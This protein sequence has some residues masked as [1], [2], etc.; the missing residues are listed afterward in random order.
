MQTIVVL[1]FHF[2]IYL[3]THS[4]AQCMCDFSLLACM[5]AI[6]TNIINRVEIIPVTSLPSDP[7]SCD[8]FLVIV[9][10]MFMLTSL[11]SHSSA[12]L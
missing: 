6:Q 4:T 9:D 1:L 8:K 7:F 10:I 3:H 12:E 11:E 5:T 2:K